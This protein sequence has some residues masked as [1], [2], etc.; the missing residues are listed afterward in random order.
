MLRGIKDSALSMMVK[1]F[2]N[3]KFK[4]MGEITDVS[5]DTGASKVAVVAKMRGEI[6]PVTASIERY[7]LETEGSDRYIVL[8]EFVTSRAWLTAG[9]NQF[10]VGKRFKLP[11]AVSKML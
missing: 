8:K 3:D 9:L 11:A 6:E 1:A 10:L 4:E 5:L 2:L 7:E